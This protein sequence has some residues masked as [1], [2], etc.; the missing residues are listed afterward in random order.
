MG[1]KSHPKALINFLSHQKFVYL[2]LMPIM[3][4]TRFLSMVLFNLRA[5]DYISISAAV[6]VLIH[7]F[8]DRFFGEYDRLVGQVVIFQASSLTSGVNHTVRLTN[9]VLA[10]NST[11]TAP[12]FDID[13]ILVNRSVSST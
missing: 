8:S 1:G 12:N 2:G 4:S 6:N 11:A 10:K 3:V 9:G 5:L 7:P 13:F